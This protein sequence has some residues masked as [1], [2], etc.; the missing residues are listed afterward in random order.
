M[1]PGTDMS[2]TSP[3]GAPLRRSKYGLLVAVAL[4]AATLG[5]SVASA[6]PLPQ[7][8]YAVQFTPLRGGPRSHFVASF[9]APFVA[10]GHRTFYYIEAFGPA[11][12]A[13]AEHD[14]DAAA[15]GQPITLTLSRSDVY[16]PTYGVR[17]WCRGS[18]IANLIY[19]SPGNQPD[20]L[21][22]HFRFRVR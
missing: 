9:A 14:S 21:I 7:T 2:T 16:L 6:D 18:Y 12:C 10:D 17:R 20:V 15:Q 11:G 8:K 3:A 22:G 13:A 5:F 1:K 19:Q 4:L